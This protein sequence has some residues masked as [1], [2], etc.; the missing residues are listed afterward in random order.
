MTEAH[1]RRTWSPVHSGHHPK[2]ICLVDAQRT[3]SL[4][5]FLGQHTSQAEY[6][7]SYQ[8]GVAFVRQAR[9]F[10]A[11]GIASKSLCFREI[12]TQLCRF[13]ERHCYRASSVDGI[14]PPTCSSVPPQM[15]SSLCRT[16]RVCPSG[17]VLH[18]AG[19]KNPARVML[20]Q[21]R[22]ELGTTVES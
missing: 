8:H 10:R 16:S 17:V 9:P 22:A 3:L 18:Q 5:S 2:H 15:F 1:I 12:P 4:A 20:A 14:C 11:V 13:C 7:E 6:M 19:K 21:V